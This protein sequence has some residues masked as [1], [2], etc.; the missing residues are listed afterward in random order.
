MEG[1]S[2]NGASHCTAVCG[3]NC[4]RMCPPRAGRAK[5]INIRTDRSNGCTRAVLYPLAHLPPPHRRLADA[6]HVQKRLVCPWRMSVSDSRRTVDR[7]FSIDPDS[8]M[9]TGVRLDKLQRAG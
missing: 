2:T 3:F 6:R 5:D 4:L 8:K 1:A 7:D 9:A